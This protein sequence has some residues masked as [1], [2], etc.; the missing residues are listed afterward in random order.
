MRA[1]IL[2][3]TCVILLAT[4]QAAYLVVDA[5]HHSDKKD[6]TADDAGQHKKGDQDV[7]VPESQPTDESLAKIRK[8]HKK[9]LSRD[10]DKKDKDIN[11]SSALPSE[12]KE[13]SRGTY[14]SYGKRLRWKKCRQYPELCNKKKPGHR[15]RK[16]QGRRD[17]K[18]RKGRKE[19]KK[20]RKNKN[21]YGSPT[22]PSNTTSNSVQ[23]ILELSLDPNSQKDSQR[24]NIQ[25]YE[26]DPIEAT[27]ELYSKSEHNT[28][29]A[30]YYQQ[31][32]IPDDK[33]EEKEQETSIYDQMI[34]DA[35]QT[36][37]GK[38]KAEKKERQEQKK[39]NREEK[40]KAR[41]Q[42]KEDREQKKAERK[43]KKSE[44]VQ[45]KADRIQRKEQKKAERQQRKKDKQEKRVGCETDGDC[46]QGECCIVKRN[47][48]KSCRRGA[49][50][51]LGKKCESSCMC[52]EGLQCFVS[53][54][55]KRGK[56]KRQRPNHRTFG[57]CE[58]PSEVDLH[59]GYFM[60]TP[61]TLPATKS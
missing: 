24:K 22:S 43:E 21:K 15:G 26:V 44:R 8:H 20:G 51:E 54:T 39:A 59:S 1:L 5:K 32:N 30:T 11:R 33:K 42:K 52:K 19:R 2:I 56:K 18:D 28:S 35:P 60:T 47:G 58:N 49:F 9:E 45:K 27:Q 48:K 53:D 12:K 50:K 37:K 13:Y 40:H 61:A 36:E 34:G 10:E 17:H 38:R 4:M 57:R 3:I 29:T 7:V 14:L 55:N 31:N 6:I 16:G 23:Q 25:S 41:K 46:G